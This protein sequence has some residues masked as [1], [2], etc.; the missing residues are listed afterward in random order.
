MSWIDSI[1]SSWRLSVLIN[2]VLK[3]Y[4]HCSRGVRQGNPLFPLLFCIAED[5]ISR[6][7]SRM[8]ESS[9]LLPISSPRGLVAPT[10]LFYAN[11]VLIFY[12]GTVKNLKSIMQAFDVYKGL[13]SQFIKWSKSS[14]FFGLSISHAWI[15]RLQYLVG[16]QIEHLPFSYLGVLLFRGKPTGS[17]LQPVVDKIISKFSKWK[18]KALCMVGRATLIKS[19]ITGSF[20]HSVM[21]YKWPSLLLRLINRNLR[22]F[23]WTDLC[24][25][26]KLIWVA[27][28]RCFRPLSNDGLGLK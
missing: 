4:F 14:I 15:G 19:V 26:S 17:L 23:L 11:D 25:E 27:W 22:N 3:G 6:F 2:R 12:R 9:L 1:L 28:N 8:V 5:F 13:S 10:H 21:I 16:M 7:L 24:E 18:G 20:V